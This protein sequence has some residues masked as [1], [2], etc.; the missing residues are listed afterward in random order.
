MMQGKLRVRGDLPTILRYVQAARR[1]RASVRHG[2]DHGSPTRAEAV[3]AVVFAEAGR[4]RGGRRA[5]PALERAHRRHRPRHACRDLRVGPALLPREGPDG[6]RAT[7]SGH[8]AVGVVEAVGDRRRRFAPGDR[9]VVAFDI[10]C[11]D[12]LV[13]PSRARRSSASDSAILGAG[14]VRRRPARRAGRARSGAVG[15]R[16]P[17]AVPDERRR[18]ARACSSA[19]CSPPASTRPRSPSLDPTTWWRW[20][21][22]GPW[23]CSAV[24]ALRALGVRTRLRARPRTRSRSR[25]PRRSA[26][27]PVNIAERNAQTAVA[28]VTDGRGADVVIEAV[29]HRRRVRVRHRRGAPWGAGRRRR[30]V[31][32]RDRR[33]A[34]RRRTGRARSTSGSPASA[35][36]TRWWD[37][38]WR[39]ASGRASTRCR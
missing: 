6:A 16:E 14:A 21:A 10:A 15:R 4:R 36:S 34:A 5:R 1:A 39:G 37:G 17:A 11:G 27:T 12:V 7:C 18:R 9:V 20:S 13:L 24:Q 2:A 38:R 3:R 25:S 19:T 28:E 30:H 22:W 23:G 32:G 8:E 26:P 31:R 35:P 29:G 33:A